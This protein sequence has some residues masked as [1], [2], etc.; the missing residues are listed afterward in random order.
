MPRFLDVHAR[1]DGS[2]LRKLQSGPVDEFGIIYLNI[3]Y[4]A[5]TLLLFASGP[6]LVDHQGYAYDFHHVYG[7]LLPPLVASL[8]VALSL[9]VRP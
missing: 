1:L 6:S 3:L 4:I 2:L 8:L 9:Q 7:F 5:V